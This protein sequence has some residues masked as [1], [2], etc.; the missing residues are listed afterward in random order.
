MIPDLRTRLAG[1]AKDTP[2]LHALLACGRQPAS[3]A[4]LLNQVDETARWLVSKGIGRADRVAVVMPNGPEMASLFLGV[5][6][7]STCAPLNPAYR[8]SEFEF[9]LSDLKPKLVIVDAALD[10]AVRGAARAMEIEI[11]ELHRRDQGVAGSFKLGP[12]GE[13]AIPDVAVDYAQGSDVALV[14]HTSGTTSRPK[15]VPLTHENLC[16]SAANIAESLALTPGDRCLNI[17][18]LFHV[19]GLVGALLSSLSVGASVVCTPGYMATEFFAWL[20]EFHP[21]WYTGVPTMHHGIVMR[22]EANRAIIAA[23]PLR[24]IRSCSS[25]LAPKLMAQ[26][27][28]AFGAPVIEAYGMTEAAHQ[29][30]SNG[31]PPRQRKPGSVGHPAGV[32]VAIMN[33]A[34][35][36]LPPGAEG[37]VVIR[38]P[39]VTRGYEHNPEANLKSFT[40]GWFRTG[41]QGRFDGDGDLFL[42]GRIKELIVR[43]GEKISPREIDE[44]LLAHPAVEQALAFAVPDEALGERA[45]AAVVVKAG[46][47]VTEL[48]LCEFAAG[49]LAAFKTPEKIIFLD[50]LPKGPT[51]KTQRIGLAQRL[52]LSGLSKPTL[53]RGAEYCAPRNETE[54]QLAEMWRAVLKLKRAGVH[55]NFFEAGG[56]SILA[57]QLI[58]RMRQTFTVE[59]SAPRL[60]Q[61]PTIAELAEFI[62]GQSDGKAADFILHSVSRADGVLLTSAQQR[63]WFFAQLEPESAVYNRPFAYRLKGKVDLPRLRASLSALVQRHEILRTNYIERDGTAIGVVR[64][65]YPVQLALTDLSGQTAEQWLR[66]E[67]ARP[68]NLQADPVLR[69]ALAR[70]A[71]DEHILLFVMHHIACDASTETLIM[72]ELA[73]AYNGT[74]AD[75]PCPQYADYAAW[76]NSREAAGREENLAWWK[77]QLQGMDEAA[78]ITGD[79]PRPA[80]DNYNGSSVAFELK[81]GT[82]ERCK[83]LAQ[84]NRTTVFS[85]LLAAFDALLHRYTG[86][87]DIVAGTPVAVRNHPATQSMVGLF[88]N[89]LALRTS[90]AGDPTF[91][92][93]LDRMRDTVNGGLEHQETP[94]D[95]VVDAVRPGRGIA[96]SALFQ[97]M[98]E[99]RNIDKPH[100]AMDGVLAERI[101][102]D[103]GFTPFDLIL[104]M[105]PSD[106][107]LRGHFYYNTGLFEHRTIERMAR[108]FET[109]LDDALQ[110]PGKMLSQ[111]SLMTEEEQAQVLAWGRNSKPYPV[112]CVHELFEKQVAKTPDAM[113]V[114][115]EDTSISYIELNRHSNQLAHALRKLGVKPDARVAICMERG[116]EMIVAML[117]VLKAGGAYVPLDPA[118][119][120]E[121]LRVMLDK[122]SPVALLTQGR[123]QD[124]MAAISNDLQVLDLTDV[125]AAWKNMPETNIDPAA[126]GLDA[127]HLA[128]VI[129]TSGSTGEPKGVMVE[130]RSV[131]NLFFGLNDSVYIAQGTSK[132]RVAVNG[133]MTFDTSVKQFI[134]L[135]RG[136]VLDIVPETV[137][138]DCDALLRFVRER[139]VDVLDCTPSQLRLLLDVGLLGDDI[140]SPLLVLVGGEPIDEDS[141]K[142]M[143]ESSRIQFFNLYGPTEC[144]VDACICAVSPGI[145]PSIGR[146]I[147]NTRIY[148]LDAHLRPVP[149]GVPGELFIGGEGVARG[150]LNRDELTAERFLADA[151][152]S[153]RGARMYRSGDIGRWLVDG[154]IEFLGRNDFQVKIRGF[155]V[156]IGE[157][158]RCLA[159]HS[160][161]REAAVMA[162]EDTPG[163]KRLVAYYT[164]SRIEGPGEEKVSTE[165]LRSHLS[166]NLPEYMRPAAYV[167][168]VR[169]PLTPHGKL[170]RRALPAPA[171]ED[172]SATSRYIAPRTPMEYDLAAIWQESLGVERIGIQENFFD[173]G[174]H[175]LS[176]MR[177]VARIRREFDLEVS[178][179]CIFESPTIES[180]AIAI[181]GMRAEKHSEEDMLRL[182]DEIDAMPALNAE[183]E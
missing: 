25:A 156:E 142:R 12:P 132:L 79:F 114:L 4:N 113:A 177:V 16:V 115:Y 102:F 49:R 133:P 99:Y 23:H 20:A 126:I 87:E 8:A 167:R 119:P 71:P 165:R 111:L 77:H 34:G 26:L 123:L 181:D 141:W 127:N 68:F 89:T 143:A 74:L 150:Y 28:A 3:F 159:A 2:H 18:P 51:G 112:A 175:S 96:R 135:L 39:N 35:E 145:R 19:H 122:S 173:I 163:E 105:E 36:L 103:R 1:I 109:L 153:D 136:S 64:E 22:A 14:L 171:M 124:R 38:G 54:T 67:S 160:D 140:S 30:T 50:E 168:L 83:A 43:G 93:F 9:Y 46:A 131:M 24:F 45:A 155:R 161:V 65:A 78:E 174:G 48:E 81:A 144:T 172:M 158:E 80:R 75:T 32:D 139:K 27:E 5:A 151:F 37:E 120:A 166:A 6:S 7:V 176:A 52:G 31:L 179:S 178:V 85:V 97:A 82:L 137:R 148:I 157:I 72:E 58:A 63:M 149:I 59:L 118:D 134:Q 121:R 21:T 147:A 146:P 17:M 91:R 41:D 69:C 44:V 152:V 10:S 86:A 162:R 13:Q 40:N 182:L 56:D 15:I 92:E 88:I 60:F 180:L 125:N 164:A 53:T 128:Y 117:A 90:A 98:F 154:N 62:R 76:Q 130:H 106:G 108:H 66:E 70:I 29:M 110:S 11:V 57:S 73:Q 33:E 95:A 94:F 170:D 61:L 138:H 84:E 183:S 42:T 101:E 100:L 47:S 55:D 107:G 116:I 129:Y 104:D 169:L